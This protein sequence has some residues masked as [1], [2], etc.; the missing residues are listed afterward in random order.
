MTRA[1]LRAQAQSFDKL[2]ADYDRLGD[3]GENHQRIAQWLA[4]V[5]PGA[6]GRALDLGCGTGRHTMLRA[7][8]FTRVDAVDL[9]QP[10]IGLARARR[11]RPN[12]TYWTSD[13]HD[14]AGPQ[15]Y[16]CILSVLTLHH[17]PDLHAALSHIRSLLA[18]GGRVVIADCYD[19]CPDRPSA[20][21]RLR[22]AAGWTTSSATGCSAG[23]RCRPAARTCSPAPGS[24]FSAGPAGSAWSGTRPDRCGRAGQMPPSMMMS[25]MTR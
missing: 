21:W 5:L 17:V 14:V 9:A 8:R 15:R 19:I 7:D 24:R 3:L 2:A 11:P 25:W 20:W 22:L 6:G 1:A 4:G 12:V 23:T 18:P 16:D 10:M 13:L